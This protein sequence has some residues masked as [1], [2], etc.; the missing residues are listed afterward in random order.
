M[1]RQ[2]KSDAESV[3]II[4]LEDCEEKY[5]LTYLMTPTQVEALHTSCISELQAGRKKELQQWHY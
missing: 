5:C 1:H 2:P 3:E 4:F